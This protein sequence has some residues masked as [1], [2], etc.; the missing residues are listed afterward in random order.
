MLIICR[1]CNKSYD[2]PDERFKGL[3]TSFTLTCPACKKAIPVDLENVDIE[4]EDQL[5]EPALL[6]G[7]DL[8][9]KI[10]LSINDLPPMPQ[11]IQKAR[12]VISDP[13]SDFKDLAKVI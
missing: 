13:N 3:G 6:S 8:K 11:V 12:Q 10:L 7:E 4:P 1:D 5:E 2:I 9:K